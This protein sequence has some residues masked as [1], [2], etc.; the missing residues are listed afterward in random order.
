MTEHN[1]AYRFET[2]LRGLPENRV[3]CRHCSGE[4]EAVAEF[5]RSIAMKGI[6]SFQWRHVKTGIEKCVRTFE[7]EPYDGWE[8]TRKI[9]A[10]EHNEV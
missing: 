7:A 3:L 9:E 2:P 6:R 5:H 8:A 10:A 4:L 1:H